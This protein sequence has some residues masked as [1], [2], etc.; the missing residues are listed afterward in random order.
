MNDDDKV[1]VIEGIE[2]ENKV[3]V[4]KLKKT[5]LTYVSTYVIN[6]QQ[7]THIPNKRTSTHTRI[8]TL[9]SYK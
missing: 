6:S 3:K 5:S 7:Q 9:Q 2:L 1:F 4:L 8:L